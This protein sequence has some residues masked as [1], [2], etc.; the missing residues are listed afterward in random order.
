MRDPT[1]LVLALSQLYDIRVCTYLRLH[2]PEPSVSCRHSSV[3]WAVGH[4]SPGVC[5]YQIILLG[6]RG[7]CVLSVVT[8]QWNGWE[9]YL[10]PFE[11]RN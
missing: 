1:L 9:L 6:N 4:T 10:R 8:W 5:W 3:T 11:R 7:T 2:G